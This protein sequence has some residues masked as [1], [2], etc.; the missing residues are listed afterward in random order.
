MHGKTAE[1]YYSPM[2]LLMGLQYTMYLS[3]DRGSSL[4]VNDC[5]MDVRLTLDRPSTP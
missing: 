4:V 2:I 3:T 5:T 1:T